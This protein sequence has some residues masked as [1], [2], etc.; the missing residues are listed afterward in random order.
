MAGLLLGA[1]LLWLVFGPDTR[2]PPPPL[3]ALQVIE[4]AD[5]PLAPGQAEALGELLARALGH[6][7]RA[8]VA[9]PDRV[10][11]ILA[12]D[13]D[14]DPDDAG[15]VFER[16]EALAG[17]DYLVRV[18][19]AG[20][21]PEGAALEIRDREGVRRQA[22]VEHEGPGARVLNLAR[23][24]AEDL[25]LQWREYEAARVVD[26]ADE[27]L[28]RMLLDALAARA[29]GSPEE[30]RLRLATVTDQAPAL[31]FA[32]YE[33]AVMAEA[34]G[35]TDR[36]RALYGAVAEAAGQAG[37]ENLEGAALFR[38]ALL[39]GDDS[40]QAMAGLERALERFL[41]AGHRINAGH[42]RSQL[43]AQAES[44]GDLEL[45][46]K[47]QARALQDFRRGGDRGGESAVHAR[48]AVLEA[49][50]GDLHA[51]RDHQRRALELQQSLG[52]DTMQAF[53]LA[54]LGEL[55]Q[56]LGRPEQARD[57]LEQARSRATGVAPAQAAIHL[58]LAR[59]ERSTGRLEAAEWHIQ[60]ALGLYQALADPAGQARSLAEGAR[61]A[62]ETGHIQRAG[63][64]MDEA[65]ALDEASARAAEAGQ[66]LAL[67][68]RVALVSGDQAG[69][70]ERMADLAARLS[71]AADPGLALE[72][73]LLVARAEPDDDRAVS[74][75]EALVSDPL[76]V[77][78]PELELEIV[79]AH[80]RWLLGRGE[81]EAARTAMARLGHRQAGHPA[82]IRLRAAVALAD[83]EAVEATRWLER[84]RRHHPD[85]WPELRA[86]KTVRLA[87]VPRR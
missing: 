42:A 61:I 34:A 20:D 56:R 73:D 19:L 70:E 2:P 43:G 5:D 30:A 25:G 14:L 51:A 48:L 58:A 28:N 4:T 59:L 45:A 9:G 33:L 31:L 40:E 62:L 81:I 6:H 21:R 72:H 60:R 78:R 69:F 74:V 36:A 71:E 13:G 29:A 64:R 83:G 8:L 66:R 39:A 76:L 38:G 32:R 27:T 3:V 49:L 55:E 18:A 1:G 57:L 11:P 63:T 23:E 26:G 85:S 67:A 37:V 46:T 68:A 41:A 86:V 24:V 50:A 80:A 10:D 65:L 44:A 7:G 84:W 52:L 15:A 53:S 35:E 47:H 77:R 22:R 87:S 79:E 16:L 82:V 17:A 54:N 75:W 12:A